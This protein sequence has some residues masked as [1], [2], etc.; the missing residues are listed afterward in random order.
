ML[1][2]TNR[3]PTDNH[4]INSE[5]VEKR[6]ENQTKLKKESK[7]PLYMIWLKDENGNLTA[8]WTIQS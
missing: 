8:H 5:L 2:N 1:L 3:K 7:S 6:L 4:P